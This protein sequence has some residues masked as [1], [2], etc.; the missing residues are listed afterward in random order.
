MNAM[1]AFVQK[2]RSYHPDAKIVLLDGPMLTGL[3]MEECRRALDAA[4]Q[5][6]ENQ[7]LNGI[8]RFSFEPRGDS[9]SYLYFHP[10]KIEALEDATRM[11]AWMRSE[12]GWD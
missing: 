2:L 5:T 4:K 8:Y 11:S 7:G 9:P 10:T 6:L 1:I 3:Y 12:F